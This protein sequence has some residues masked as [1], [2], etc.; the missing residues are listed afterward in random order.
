MLTGD[1]P[2]RPAR[3]VVMMTLGALLVVA[4]AGVLQERQAVQHYASLAIS[5]VM[6]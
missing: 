5:A 4:F 3:Q 6:N 1:K 2:A